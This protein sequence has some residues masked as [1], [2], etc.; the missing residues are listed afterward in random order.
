MIGRRNPRCV[1]QYGVSA[2]R[3][4]SG[5]HAKGP[6][7]L[8][9][10]SWTYQARVLDVPAS[11]VVHL[12]IDMGWRTFR[13]ELVTLAGISVRDPEMDG[14][15]EARQFLASLLPVG[16]SVTL[17]SIGIDPVSGRTHGVVFTDGSKHVA[18]RLVEEGFALPWDGRSWR[19]VPS[20]PRRRMRMVKR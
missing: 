16:A 7:L 20:W 12:E 15:D 4:R 14:A 5:A 3:D 9:R 6:P 1:G 18:H 2:G 8:A 10:P 13:R 11:G 19:R 17:H